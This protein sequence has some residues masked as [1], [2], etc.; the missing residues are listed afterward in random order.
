MNIGMR[1]DEDDCRG[2]WEQ[3]KG[4]E[5]EGR[6]QE[7]DWKGREEEWNIWGGRD[8]WKNKNRKGE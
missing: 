4:L 5:E 1:R 6:V 3:K 2:I 7:M 8:A